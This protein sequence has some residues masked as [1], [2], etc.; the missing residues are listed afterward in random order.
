[1]KDQEINKFSF[2]VGGRHAKTL[3]KTISV[4]SC[5]FG[6]VEVGWPNSA[7]DSRSTVDLFSALRWIA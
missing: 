5:V 7:I 1:M 6:K 4:K 2:R 3:N